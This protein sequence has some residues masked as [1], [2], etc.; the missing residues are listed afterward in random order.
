MTQEEK[1]LVLKDICTRLPYGV[2]VEISW[3]Y[4]KTDVYTSLEYY[5]FPNIDSLLNIFWDEK[6]ISIKPY[7][8]SMSSMTEEEKDYIKNVARFKQSDG[9]HYDDGV[10]YVPI[11]QETLDDQWKTDG[12][13]PPILGDI[14]RFMLDYGY[15]LLIDFFN[16][17]HI[18]YRGLIPKGFALEAPIDMY[19]TL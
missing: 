1:E 6:C 9:I 16:S 11:Y 10:H 2:H 8:R 17:H 19:K 14:Y 4:S 3:E 5:E 7:L 12:K 13:F 15:I 18:D